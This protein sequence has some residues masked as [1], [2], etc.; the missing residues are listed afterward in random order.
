MLEDMYNYIAISRDGKAVIYKVELGI[1][2]EKD[3]QIF[4]E[5]IK[6][7]DRIIVQGQYLLKNNDN[8]KEV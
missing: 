4:L 5:E 3:Q 8:L 7:G 2:T 1:S 6:E